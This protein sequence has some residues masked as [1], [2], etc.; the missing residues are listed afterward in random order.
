V[1]TTGINVYEIL[2]SRDRNRDEH[3]QFWNSVSQEISK[4]VKGEQ[5]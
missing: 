5:M 1:D 3:R 4:Y 2:T